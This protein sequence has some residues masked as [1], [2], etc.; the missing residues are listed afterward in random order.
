MGAFGGA[1]L[2][3]SPLSIGELGNYTQSASFSLG[4]GLAA[5]FN[6]TWSDSGFQLST[7]FGVGLGLK[8]NIVDFGYSK[9]L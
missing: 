1:T 6:A 8:E 9:D 3:G 4:V 2:E 7:G 5:Q